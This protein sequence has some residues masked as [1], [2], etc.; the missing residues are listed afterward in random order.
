MQ[1]RAVLENRSRRFFGHI[2]QQEGYFLS[3]VIA[4]MA[5]AKDFHGCTKKQRIVSS[6]NRIWR[7][8]FY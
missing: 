1:K 4:T 3:A 6:A 2:G 8:Y 7:I 5:N